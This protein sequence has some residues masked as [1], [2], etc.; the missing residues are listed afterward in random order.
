M[1]RSQK[2]DNMKC[3]VTGGGGFLGRYIV[4]QLHARGDEVRVFGRRRY[5]ELDD[6]G[7]ETL[8][9]DIR[10]AAAVADACRDADAVFHVAAVPGVWGPWKTYYGI[11]TEGTQHVIDA[12]RRRG[13]PKLVYTSS[14]SVIFDEQPHEGVDET[15]P[16]PDASAYLCHYPHSKAIAER[17]VLAA[18]CDELATVSLRPHLIWGPRDNHLIPRLIQRAKNGRL[19]RVGDG[20][21]LVSLTYVENAAAAHLQAADALKAGSRV[22]GQT[23]FINDPEPVNLWQWIDDVL[24]RAGLPPVTKSISA[25]S[26]WRIGTALETIYRLLHLPGE[27]PMTRFVTLQLSSSHYYSIAKAERDF[28]YQPLVSVKEGMRRLEVDLRRLS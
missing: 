25:K 10:D 23:Y 4:E 6:L 24:K 22:A 2:A 13:V 21:N 7:V 15:Y 19:R 11:N 14:P 9:G 17:A 12:C 16:Y 27:P 8:Q 26:A 20:Q 3:V 28:G 1:N 5:P 18:N